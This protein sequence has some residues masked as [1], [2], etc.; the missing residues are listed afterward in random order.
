MGREIIYKCEMSLSLHTG[1]G[2][3]ETTERCLSFSVLLTA[4]PTGVTEN[5]TRF[6][7]AGKEMCDA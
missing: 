3:G 6:L 5:N 2:K 1:E 4:C 7:P